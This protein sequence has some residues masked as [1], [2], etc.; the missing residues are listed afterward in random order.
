MS[1][2]GSLCNNAYRLILIISIILRNPDVRICCHHANQTTS[3]K[4][5]PRI[6]CMGSR[7]HK[8]TCP[9][10]ADQGRSYCY[11][12]SSFHY[13]IRVFH[14]R[15]VCWWFRRNT[16]NASC[17]DNKVKSMHNQWKED[18]PRSRRKP[19]FFRHRTSKYHCRYDLRSN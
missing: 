18:K 6:R 7:K 4:M 12:I 15:C 16:Q 2:C 3:S 1:S 19:S 13:F 11:S 9:N 5:K 14:R 17:R 10:K 8:F